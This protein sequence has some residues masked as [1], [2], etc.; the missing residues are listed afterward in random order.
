MMAAAEAVLATHPFH[1]GV[2][3]R[4]LSL[5]A[6]FVYPSDMKVASVPSTRIAK[7]LR[8]ALEGAPST[9]FPDE[10]L[11]RKWEWVSSGWLLSAVDRLEWMRAA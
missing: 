5:S 10:Q 3:S 7:A 9:G 1:H 4:V 6:D 11:P 2:I 8:L